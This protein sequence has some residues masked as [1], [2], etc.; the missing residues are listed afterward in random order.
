MIGDLRL[1]QLNAPVCERFKAN[2][3]AKFPSRPYARKI[4]TS[5]KGILS[6]ARTQGW[7]N[8]DPAENV[9]I[10]LSERN[11]PQHRDWPTL[12]EIAVVLKKADEKASSTNKQ[13]QNRWERYRAFV[14]VAVF[15]GMRPGEVLG[16][17]WRNVLFE[18][19]AIRVDQDLDEDGTI[20]RPK[21]KAAYRTIRMPDD[22]MAMLEA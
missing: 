9:R 15:S 4:L 20:G 13:L 10:V 5:F 22:V 8:A 19:G 11:R 17:P 1:N 21:S 12:G 18:E 14:Y 3:L 7:L 2:L 16:L 6:E